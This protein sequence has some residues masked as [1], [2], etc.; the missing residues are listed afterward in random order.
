MQRIYVEQRGDVAT[1][2][3]NDTKANV[4]NK[5]FFDQIQS[6][7]VDLEEDESVKAVVLTGQARFFSAGLDLKSLPALPRDELLPVLVQFGEMTLQ[8]FGFPKP[9]VAAVNG[10]ALAGGCVLMLCCDR[11]LVVDVGAKIGLNEVAIGL[12]LPTF[13]SELA[14]SVLGQT[15]LQEAVMEAR[16]Y[17]PQGALAIGYADRL[18]APEDLLREAGAVAEQLAQLP[19][20]AYGTTKRRIREAALTRA[21]TAIGGEIEDFLR[22]G[23]FS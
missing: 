16:I 4:L 22:S 2:T 15:A 11:R 10:H 20:S 1:I 17:D 21:Q 19:T 6:A 23:P 9:L 13:V 12:A 18:C 5:E 8:L 3:M 14:R 7:L